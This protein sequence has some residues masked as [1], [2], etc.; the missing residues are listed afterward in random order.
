MIIYIYIHTYVYP[1]CCF[2][3]MVFFFISVVVV[4]WLSRHFE[5]GRVRC[6]RKG[7]NGVRTHDLEVDPSSLREEKGLALL[8]SLQFVVWFDRGTF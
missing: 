4:H 1:L 8:G 3:G 2:L 5:P 7:T 6:H